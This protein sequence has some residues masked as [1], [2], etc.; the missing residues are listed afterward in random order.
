[1]YFYFD[2]KFYLLVIFKNCITKKWIKIKTSH[3]DKA[4][5]KNGT[6]PLFSGENVPTQ[7]GI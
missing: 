3:V 7:F 5:D 1:M 4:N 2:V 6:K